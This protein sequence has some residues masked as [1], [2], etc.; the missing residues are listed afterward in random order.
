MKKPL[1]KFSFKNLS[2]RVKLPVVLLVLSMIPLL[3]STWFLTG[4]FSA[5][6][7]SDREQIQQDIAELN[8]ARI[9]E[10]MQLK[11]SEMEELIKQHPEFKSGDPKKILPL[12]KLLDESDKQIDGFNLVNASGDG[13]DVNNVAINV[14]DR[15]YFKQVKETKK[16]AISDML[17]SKKT[18]KYVLPI[19]VPILDDSGSFVGIVSATVSPDTL[20]NLMASVKVGETGFGYIVSGTGDYYTHP[21]KNRIGKQVSEYEK[22]ASSQEAFKSMRDNQSGAVTYIGDNGKEVFGYYGTIPNTSWKLLVVAPTNEIYGAVHKAQQISVLFA[23]AAALLIVLVAFLIS[24]LSVKPIIAISTVMKKVADG[25]LNERLRVFAEDE[26]GQMSRNINVTIDS[27]AGMV[28][29]INSTINRVA[30]ASDELLDSAGQSSR[31]SAQIAAS[32]QEVASGTD[33]QLQGAEQSARAMEE[34]AAGVQRIAESSGIVS[35]RSQD[36]TNE[37]ESGYR[38][39]QSAIEQMNVIGTAAGETAAVIGQ[40]SKHS[41][42]IG[43]IVDVISEIANQTSLLALNASIEAARAGEQG[44]GFAVVANEVKKLAEQT[45]QSVAS[46]VGLIQ[47]IQ[48]TSA[49]AASSMEHNVAE[50]DDGIRKMLHIGEAFGTIRSSIRNVAEQIQEV[51]ATT[52]QISAGTEQITASI[53]DMVHVAKQSADNSQA[54]A[55]STEE[56]SAIMETIAA[57]AHNL[58]KLTGELKEMVKVFRV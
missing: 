23:V 52:E 41:D 21:D 34:M 25:Y 17:V 57:S 6:T 58:N 51:S 4:Y 15:A 11:I 50:I 29:Q 40:L 12:L 9:D 37:L 48:S 56:Q 8:I 36:V 10:W 3:A 14:A 42:E 30:I 54:V 24:R 33:A 22:S 38:D 45:N 32:I 27:L 39:I 16:P 35:D 31:A 5:I 13:I 26:L 28:G 18:G 44:R 53:A 20:T 49:S 19:A 46:I 55:S 7:K 1:S 43:H 2:I 47:L